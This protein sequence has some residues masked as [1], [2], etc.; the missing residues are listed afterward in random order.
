MHPTISDFLESL[1]SE[2]KNPKTIDTYR[3]VLGK[4]VKWYEDSTGES[5]QPE[6]VTDVD[7]AEYK[8]HLL[9]YA[10]PATINKAQIP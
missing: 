9:K 10:K 6:S 7:T 8:R 3:D 1:R 2:G 5:F 4:F